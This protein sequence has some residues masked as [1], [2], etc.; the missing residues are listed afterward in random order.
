ME[1]S[2]GGRLQGPE[3]MPNNCHD[4]YERDCHLFR[5]HKGRYIHP[6]G[7]RNKREMRP[8]SLRDKIDRYLLTYFPY[9]NINRSG[10]EAYARL[11]ST[12]LEVAQINTSLRSVQ[13]VQVSFV[14]D[15][16]PQY[17]GAPV[18]LSTC[19]EFSDQINRYEIVKRVAA[20]LPMDL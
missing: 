6:F 4:H 7:R 2:G 17:S 8:I 16:K 14:Q 9:S 18:R 5:P 1:I 10:A 20:K 11:N 15:W 19:S 12:A 13:T 3:S